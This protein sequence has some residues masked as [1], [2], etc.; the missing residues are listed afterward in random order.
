MSSYFAT[1]KNIKLADRYHL[2]TAQLADLAETLRDVFLKSIEVEKLPEMLAAKL[3]IKKETAFL[4]ASEAAEQHFT[5]QSEYLGDSTSLV[6]KWRQ[7]G[8]QLG[9]KQ[10]SPKASTE[11]E[12]LIANAHSTRGKKPVVLPDVNRSA[13]SAIARTPVVTSH[14]V[15][16]ATFPQKRTVGQKIAEKRAAERAA[17]VPQ[18]APAGQPQVSPEARERFLSQLRGLTIDALREGGQSAATR[19]QQAQQKIGQVLASSPGDRATVSQ[20]LRQSPLFATYQQLGQETI[21]SG[22][23]IDM[24]IY[25]RYQQG[26]PYL[27][28]DEFDA[29][30]SLIKLVG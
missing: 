25:Q 26:Q 16:R 19:L 6:A 10:P 17:E 23:P 9:G 29:V 28:R 20:A 13:A 7:W 18:Q 30:A 15:K 11:V 24:V 8:R 3:K 14:S 4:L 1:L 22:Q 5:A 12:R 27:L 21:R 2:S